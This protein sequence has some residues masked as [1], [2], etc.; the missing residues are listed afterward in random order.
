[1]ARIASS[2]AAS[3]AITS[4]LAQGDRINRAVGAI[5]ARRPEA[6]KAFLALQSALRTSG[7]LSP[8]LV[9]LIR[10]RI[11]FHNQCRSCMAIRYRSAID[12]GVTEDT[13]CS[14]ERPAEA[15]DLSA[16]ER[17]A[18]NFADL[19]ATNHLA[20]DG[21]VYDEL[22]QHFTEDELVELGLHCATMVGFGRMVA[23]WD[24]A[25]DLPDGLRCGT[26]EPF[27]PW[28]SKSVVASG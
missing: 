22:R 9:E 16:A 10:L 4:A 8:R 27:A 17:S 14:L 15:A 13:V 25:D 1:M 2:P 21:T 28:R 23:T 19:F 5:L 26:G 3:S 7:T 18:L 20:I 11:A 6:A 24:V 12:D